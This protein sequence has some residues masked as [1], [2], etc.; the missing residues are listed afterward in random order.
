MEKEFMYVRK[1][2]SNIVQKWERNE[3]NLQR[4]HDWGFKEIPEEAVEQDEYG[5]LWVKGQK[6]EKSPDEKRAERIS[7]LRRML[8]R[9]DWY[10][11]R[12]A[13]TG[14]EIPADIL[15]ARKEA[16]EEIS[17]LRGDTDL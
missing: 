1:E 17:Q 2:T 8:D 14:K 11:A 9:T 5:R 10:V 16:R 12:K 15:K 6:P 13:E 7:S 3:R 4:A